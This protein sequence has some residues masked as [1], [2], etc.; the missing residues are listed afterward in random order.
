MAT[1]KSVSVTP[2]RRPGS[3]SPP[4]PTG[5]PG[6]GRGRTGP[7]LQRAGSCRAV[8]HGF[9]EVGDDD[10]GARLAQGRVAGPRSTPTT[11]PKWP[12]APASHAWRRRP[13]STTERSARPSSSAAAWRNVSGRRLPGEP[14]LGGDPAAH[15]GGSGSSRP[16]ALST[17]GV[18]RRR[19]DAHRHAEPV[20]VVQQEHRPGGLHPVA[21]EHDVE[22]VVL[23]GCPACTP[24]PRPERRRGRLRQPDAAGRRKYRAPVVAGLA[25]D[26]GE[27]AS[28]SE[29][30]EVSPSPS[31][32]ARNALNMSD[33]A[34]MGPSAVGVDHPVEVEQHGVVPA[35]TV[36][37]RE[38]ASQSS[39]RQRFR[40]PLW[41]AR[42]PAPGAGSGSALTATDLEAGPPSG[43]EHPPHRAGWSARRRTPCRCA[44]CHAAAGRPVGARLTRASVAAIVLRTAVRARFVGRA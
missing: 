14:E 44:P 38:E 1:V 35:V 22:R 10:A 6:S 23:V 17:A 42:R 8:R 31:Q 9:G 32:E 29:Y 18:R 34:G 20:E 24:C 4:G 13:P 40:S 39:D 19:H 26:V 30:G 27:V 7:L 33:H 11:R 15:D 37:S 25:V 28:A 36:R 5:R 21:R 43:G 3:W 12:A 16:A 2:C 41:V